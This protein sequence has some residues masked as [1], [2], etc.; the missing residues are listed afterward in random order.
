VPLA[1][2]DA[3]E[4]LA[5]RQAERLGEIEKFGHVDAAPSVSTCAMSD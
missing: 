2:L 3:V 5:R 4:Q 1:R